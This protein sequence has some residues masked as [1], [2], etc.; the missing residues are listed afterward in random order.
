MKSAEPGR[1]VLI[2]PQIEVA[3]VALGF[4]LRVLLLYQFIAMITSSAVTEKGGGKKRQPLKS[5]S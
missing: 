2:F 4:R 3:H 5:E 1:G